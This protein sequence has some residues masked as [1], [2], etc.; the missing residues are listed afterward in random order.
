M[1]HGTITH[2]HTC[3]HSLTT[4][5]KEK[6]K[7]FQAHGPP[8]PPTCG[9]KMGEGR[10]LDAPRAFMSR[11]TRVGIT[12]PPKPPSCRIPFSDPFLL[13]EHSHCG[14]VWSA[15]ELHQ[16]CYLYLFKCSCNVERDK[17]LSLMRQ[18]FEPLTTVVERDNLTISI[19]R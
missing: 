12:L 16:I 10:N 8:V 19:K 15:L 11:S 4:T 9:E 2:T 18:R 3:T 5:K 13:Q 7:V 17:K 1:D 6:K 14:I